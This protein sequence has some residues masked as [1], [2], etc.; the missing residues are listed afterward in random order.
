MHCLPI[1]LGIPRPGYS[2]NSREAYEKVP[3]PRSY[4]WPIQVSVAGS[5]ICVLNND[6]G[7]SRTDQWLGLCT[8]NCWVQS[9]A[10]ELGSYKLCGAARKKKNTNDLC[11][12][13]NTLSPIRWILHEGRP[14]LSYAVTEWGQHKYLLC[15]W[16]CKFPSPAKSFWTKCSLLSE[17]PCFCSYGSPHWE[18]PFSRRAVLQYRQKSNIL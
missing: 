5:E 4:F 7:N 13:F 11:C 9:L 16:I 18:P 14:C 17:L 15:D 12:Y 8:F 2:S 6:F 10:R 3:F 1:V